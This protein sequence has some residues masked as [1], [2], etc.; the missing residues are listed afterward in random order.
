LAATSCLVVQVIVTEA[1]TFAGLTGD[2]ETNAQF[3]MQG[4]G[5]SSSTSL[6]P[7][8]KLESKNSGRFSASKRSSKTRTNQTNP[9]T[10]ADTIVFGTAVQPVNKYNHARLGKNS[11][12]S[13]LAV[14]A[15]S[16]HVGST[17][18]VGNSTSAGPVVGAATQEGWHTRRMLKAR[19]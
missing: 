12:S 2:I 9:I 14:P 11:S 17:G 8:A 7:V 15:G 4:S 10:A 1:I 5:A 6:S 16:T 19:D 3:P 13:I 18:A